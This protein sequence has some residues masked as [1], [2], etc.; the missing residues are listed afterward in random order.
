[1]SVRSFK[2][3]TKHKRGTRAFAFFLLLM[4]VVASA[5]VS[6]YIPCMKIMAVDFNTTNAMLQMSIVMNL[7][8]EFLGRF[9]SGPLFDTYS[10]KKIVLY[11]LTI[12][13]LGHLGC[14][15]STSI[16]IFLFMRFFQALGSSVIY[17]ASVGIINS[18]FAE[19]DKSS[20]IGILE[21]YQPVAWILSPFAGGILAE[22]GSW[23]WSFAALMILQIIGLFVFLEYREQP[24]EKHV[25]KFTLKR[26]FNDYKI[27]LRNTYFLIYALIPGMFA[28]GY[29]IF[30]SNSPFICSKIFADNSLDIAMFQAVP[31]LFYILGIFVYRAVVRDFGIRP[32]KWLGTSIYVIFGVYITLL[33]AEHTPWTVNHLLA[34]MCVQCVGSAFLVP[35]SVLKAIQS[36]GHTSY[37]GAATVVVFR[38]LIMSLCITVSTR[39]SESITM[40]MGSVF[41]TVA[42]ALMLITTRRI[43]K[44]RKRRS[45]S[46]II[47]KQS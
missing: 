37:V 23:R 6:I 9:C 27:V 4:N 25:R 22:I 5:S 39:L 11:A 36:T 38:N 42:T 2:N 35:V 33:I 28:G 3:H 41:M 21:L 26:F 10:N 16:E 32:A 13:I 1:M 31:L 34:L 14:S 20:I 43:M 15:L 47:E 8:G 29:M 7:I 44:V 19:E 46:K 30:A 17:I 12:S 45:E 40:V 24:T 18:D